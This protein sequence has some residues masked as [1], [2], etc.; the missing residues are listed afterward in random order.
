[1][2]TFYVDV[3]YEFTGVI[4]VEAIDNEDAKEAVKEITFCDPWEE[5]VVGGHSLWIDNVTDEEDSFWKEPKEGGQS[6]GDAMMT[7]GWED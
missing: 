1:M 6:E 5:V 4:K 7:E 2:K 3:R